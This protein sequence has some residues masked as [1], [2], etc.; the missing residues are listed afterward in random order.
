MNGYD[1][2]LFDQ[3]QFCRRP[4]INESFDRNRSKC[5]HNGKP[6]MFNYLAEYNITGEQV[7]QWSTSIDKADQYAR[8]Y[9]SYERKSNQLFICNCSIPGTF[10]SFCEYKYEFYNKDSTFQSTVEKVFLNRRH[11]R[12]YDQIY[13][14]ILCYETLFPC[15]YGL[16]CLDWRDIC[17]GRQ[18]CMDGIDE[19]NCDKLEFDECEFDEYRCANGMCI[20]DDYFLDGKNFRLNMFKNNSENFGF[21]PKVMCTAESVQER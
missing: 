17:D 15:D 4:N 18:Q 21:Y 19:E 3:I 6:I 16:L 2:L 11:Y 10:G 13:G 8:W 5:D 20:P 14:D 9:R 12:P 7:L 1:C